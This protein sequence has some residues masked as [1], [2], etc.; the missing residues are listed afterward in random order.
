MK[1]KSQSHKERPRARRSSSPPDFKSEPVSI[2]GALLDLQPKA[3]N[4][5]VGRLV[6][7]ISSRRSSGNA[8]VLRQFAWS[9]TKL[10]GV[11]G[12]AGILRSKQYNALFA[13]LKKYAAFKGDRDSPAGLEL[14]ESIRVAAKRWIA[15]K[16]RK[17]KSEKDLAIKNIFDAA[18]TE[19][20]RIRQIIQG[21]GT[22]YRPIPAKG[23]GT[24][25]DAPTPPASPTKQAPDTS[26]AQVGPEKAEFRADPDDPA[27]ALFYAAGWFM[28][29]FHEKELEQEYQE[30]ES[31]AEFQEKVRQGE[32]PQ[33]AVASW[34]HI[35]TGRPRENIK[36]LTGSARQEFGLDPKGKPGEEMVFYWG[37]TNQAFQTKQMQSLSPGGRGAGRAIFVMTTDGKLYAGDM[38]DEYTKGGAGDP[39]RGEMKGWIFHHSSFLAG[40]PVAAAGELEFDDGGHLVSISNA[41]GHYKP[42]SPFTVQVLRRFSQIGV[43]ISGL[44]V[45]DVKLSLKGIP[46]IPATVLLDFNGDADAI[47]KKI[48]GMS[49]EELGAEAAKA[50]ERQ[51]TPIAAAYEEGFWL[52]QMA[53]KS[54]SGLA[55]YHSAL[56]YEKAGKQEL[57]L[58]MLIKAVLIHPN[59]REVM[60]APF[61]GGETISSLF[62][63]KIGAALYRKGEKLFND[64]KLD[65][66]FEVIKKLPDVDPVSP[67]NAMQNLGAILEQKGDA[68]GAAEYY[69][70][71]LA[72][73]PSADLEGILRAG[74]ARVKGNQA[75]LAPSS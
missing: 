27:Y 4:K 72:A 20:Q 68:N 53:T 50:A 66:A 38:H 37:K 18:E 35:P 49:G 64:N 22:E 60:N 8:T 48:K 2:D 10:G 36:G 6:S 11:G 55:A 65:E 61:V 25:D 28:D 12:K 40:Q 45:N 47:E 54:Q 21:K 23:R 52:E 3:G 1:R 17:A 56:A 63:S 32:D 71:G 24:A 57:V 67:P 42:S 14:V 13:A 16:K 62:A 75:N 7:Q 41:S 69:E 26:A 29:E 9:S 73:N 33:T 19:V 39:N 74:L 43:D 30:K 46:H 51:D 70:R 59:V 15:H 5:A 44:T 31:W 58:E 34:E